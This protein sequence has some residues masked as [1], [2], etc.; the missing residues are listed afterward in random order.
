MI[1]VPPVGPRTKPKA[2]SFALPFARGNYVTVYDAEDRPHPRQLREAHAVLS[3]AP[4]DVACVQSTLRIDRLGE[5]RTLGRLFAVEYAALFDGLL[6]ALAALRCP[7]RW[8]ARPTTSAREALEEVGGWDPYNVTEDA[9]LGVR[10]ARFGYRTATIDLPTLEEAP[11]TLRHGSRPGAPLVEGNY[12]M[13]F[14]HAAT[15]SGSPSSAGPHPW[16]RYPRPLSSALTLQY[17]ASLATDSPLPL[18]NGGFVLD[19]RRLNL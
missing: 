6:P 3:R 7:C 1:V 12:D 16:L 4:A 14:V 10:L 19:H 18:G 15:Q 8:V 2:L 9:D 11:P 13:V 17:H 5:A